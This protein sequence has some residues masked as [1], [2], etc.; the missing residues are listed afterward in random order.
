MIIN[1]STAF[2][3]S[4]KPVISLI[5][6]EINT[7]SILLSTD[8]EKYVVYQVLPNNKDLG[9]RLK[10]KFNKKLID[11]IKAMTPDQINL[12]K[13]S[14]KV[15]INEVELSA[16]T[17]DLIIKEKYMS[18]NLDANLALGGEDEICLL[19]DVS[20]DEKLRNVGIVR[21]VVNRVQKLRKNAG[22]NVDD[23]IAIFYDLKNNA[24]KIG[25]AI[26]NEK[27]LADQTIK[28]P[29]NQATL[30]PENAIVIKRETYEWESMS[31]EIIIIHNN[32]FYINLES[33]K[34]KSF[35][36]FNF[37]YILKK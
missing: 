27:A 14:G 26:Q 24:E 1:K 21:E 3:D 17:N 11:A 29:F 32:T 9:L 28:K 8:F 37:F 35:E 13:Q 31:Y 4:L 2:L 20:Q 19:L 18:E 15:T 34:V 16:Q 30:I 7:P 22:L 5:E 10:D 36:I 25:V 33:L 23:P 12:Y 6:D